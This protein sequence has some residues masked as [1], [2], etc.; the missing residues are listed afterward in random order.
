MIDIYDRIKIKGDDMTKRKAI[1]HPQLI[2]ISKI[3][4]KILAGIYPN[5][6]ELATELE[7]SVIT[8]S[9]DIEFMRD[10]MMAPIEY[11]ATKRGYYYSESFDMPNYSMSDK[12]IEVLAS[13]KRLLSH[14]KDTP[15]YE[16]ACDIIDLLSQ[17]VIKNNPKEYINRIAL[18]SRPQVKYDKL[19][20][21]TLWEAIKQ[22]KIIEFDYNGRWRQET[23]H[24]RV[25]PYQLLMDDG[26]FLFGYSEERCAERLFALS[27]IKNL[28]ITDEMFELPEDF[29][30]ENRCGGGKFGAFVSDTKETYKIVFFEDARPLV[31]ELVLSDDEKI[32]EDDVNECTY[33]TFSTTQSMKVLEWV[34]SLGYRAKPISPSSF[35]DTWIEEINQLKSILRN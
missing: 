35:V 9:R 30:F 17:T 19:V 27:R 33:V 10:S 4:R 2:R 12:D 18:P 34:L 21:N 13:A 8:I 25:R 14:F 3:H 23:T 15:L 1:N 11:D 6:N 28:V 22:N 20:W 29:I 24:R 16:D 5:T 7:T 26:I 32:E 31:R